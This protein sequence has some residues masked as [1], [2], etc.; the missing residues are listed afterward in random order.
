MADGSATG[1]AGAAPGKDDGPGSRAKGA[2]HPGTA[3]RL[4]AMILSGKL[5]PGERLRESHWCQVFDVSRTPF[6]E[7]VRTLAAE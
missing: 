5:P 6:R 7:A 3:Q 1:E 2:L 4:R